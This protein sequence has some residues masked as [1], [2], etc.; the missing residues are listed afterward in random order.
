MGSQFRSRYIFNKSGQLVVHSPLEFSDTVTKFVPS[1]H[2]VYFSENIIE[3]EDI[4]MARKV[5]QTLEIHKLERKCSQKGD[6]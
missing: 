5:D 4:S 1:I 6:T 3:P 2:S